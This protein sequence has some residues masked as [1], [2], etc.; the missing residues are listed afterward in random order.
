[1]VFLFIRHSFPFSST[2]LQKGEKLVKEVSIDCNGF[3]LRHMKTAV[4]T[5]EHNYEARLIYN[6]HDGLQCASLHLQNSMITCF[7][8]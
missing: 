4:C 6:R 7:N 3:Q 2:P 8:K 5:H 1:M